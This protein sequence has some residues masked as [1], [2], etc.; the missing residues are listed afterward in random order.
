MNVTPKL[1]QASLLTSN[2]LCT[3]VFGEMLVFHSVI[4]PGIAKL[5]DGGFLRTFQVIDGI[6]QNNE[7]T[8]VS[9][10]IGSIVSLIMTAVLGLKEFE[11]GKLVAL[12]VGTVAYLAGQV[13]TF[14][15]NV[16]R[17]NR[18]KMLDIDSLDDFSKMRERAFFE[19]TWNKWNSFRTVLFGLTSLDLLI[20]LLLTPSKL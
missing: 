14:T 8:F 3:T 10:W 4:M 7:P 6:I 13:S 18:V 15:I 16:P 1:F 12:I 2:F 20:L 5:D 19:P 11:G 17:N 9:F